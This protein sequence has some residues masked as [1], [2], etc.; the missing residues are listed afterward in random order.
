MDIVAF[1]TVRAVARA[2]GVTAAA[3]E[4]NCV[5][6]AITA[7]IRQIEAEIGQ[8]L[9]VRRPRGMQPTPAG[10]ILVGYAER[11]IRLVDEAALA[12]APTAAPR[13]T[14]RIGATDTSATVHL[15]AVFA[16]Y[17]EAHPQVALEVASMVTRDLLRAVREMR[18]D[19]AIV[20]AIPRDPAIRADRIRTETLVL[21]SARG[22][23][24]PFARRPATF[25][26]ARAGG[27]QRAQVEAWWRE[28]AGVPM[29]VIELPS[30][31][32]RLSFAAA[33]IG[34]TVVPASA[35]DVLSVGGALR[36]HAIP[37]PWCRQDVAL[38]T[39]ADAPRFPALEAFRAMLLEAYGAGG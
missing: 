9:F 2:G 38:A 27:A 4:L 1:R 31:G 23:A 21:A 24:D 16:R 8:P 7:R 14:L 20:N 6:S 28:A 22:I 3:V 37:E 39:R 33:G 26:A 30:I 13:G 35:L 15:P 36:L 19:C 5:P 10:E 12:L 18:L 29:E 34:L 25:L 17:H 32:L 11:A